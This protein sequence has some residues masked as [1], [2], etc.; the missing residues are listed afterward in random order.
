MSFCEPSPSFLSWTSSMTMHTCHAETRTLAGHCCPTG[1][2]LLASQH[3]SVRVFFL[4]QGP[5]QHTLLVQLSCLPISSY[6]FSSQSCLVFHDIDNLKEHS[7]GA[8]RMPHSQ[9]ESVVFLMTRLKLWVWGRLSQG[10]VPFSL[11]SSKERMT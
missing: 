4:F 2:P 6:L 10:E 7:S 3:V 8:L 11:R 1:G 9:G 5:T